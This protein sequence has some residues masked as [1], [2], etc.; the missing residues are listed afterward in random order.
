M[1]WSCGPD[2]LPK[3]L[4]LPFL[5]EDFSFKGLQ[6]A[7][8]HE[9]VRIAGVAIL[10]AVFTASIR[11]DGPGERYARG[12]AAVQLLA[13]RQRSIFYTPLLLESGA[14]R[15]K[16]SYSGEFDEL[17][18]GQNRLRR[19]LPVHSS[20]FILHCQAAAILTVRLRGQERNDTL[21]TKAVQG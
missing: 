9:F 5:S 15:C 14:L 4:R 11:I 3:C 13:R 1:A 21:L 6:V 2:F 19:C 8:F 18:H 7:Q 17:G 10:T 16:P 12:L 20:P